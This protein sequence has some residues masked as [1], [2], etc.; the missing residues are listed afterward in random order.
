M[1]GYAKQA[2]LLH[3]LSDNFHAQLFLGSLGYAGRT[4]AASPATG[5]AKIHAREQAALV[6]EALTVATKKPARKPAKKTARK[7]ARKS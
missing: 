2:E 5:S 6:D 4:A 1:I 7:P 3:R